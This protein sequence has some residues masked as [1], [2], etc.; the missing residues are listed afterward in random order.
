MLSRYAYYVMHYPSALAVYSRQY[1][2]VGMHYAL[3]YIINLPADFIIRMY[4]SFLRIMSMSGFQKLTLLLLGC[5]LSVRIFKKEYVWLWVLIITYVTFYPSIQFASRHYFY[6][7]L[8]PFLVFAVFL[9]D[10]YDLC[11]CSNIRR[12]SGK[13][14]KSLVTFWISLGVIIFT[15]LVMARYYQ[16]SHLTQIFSKYLSHDKL[17]LAYK[18]E[19]APSGR[20]LLS[21]PYIGRGLYT[22]NDKKPYTQITFTDNHLMDGPVSSAYLMVKFKQ[23]AACKNISLDLTFQYNSH[24]P[25]KPQKKYYDYSY[26]LSMLNDSTTLF[27]PVYY[28]SYSSFKA[29]IM[30]KKSSECVSNI[31]RLRDPHEIKFWSILVL[32]KHWRK[33]KLYETV[34]GK[35][36][37]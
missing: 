5:V 24:P 32:N 12:P 2:V 16:Q 30:S 6:L 18:S 9:R 25:D 27:F 28:D 10:I 4:A 23:I 36:I 3:N 33:S 13:V 14:I 7:R 1:F 31:Y 34:K 22:P 19:P 35:W 29:L 37:L 26:R 17:R 20:V 21:F 8:V 11:M 15:P